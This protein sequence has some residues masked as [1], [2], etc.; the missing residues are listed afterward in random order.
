[1]SIV[2]GACGHDCP[3]TCSWVVE[4]RDG[5]AERLSGDPAHP[6][7]RGTLCAKVNHYLERVYHPDRVLYP[8][9]R[10][11]RKGEGRFV[12]V[13]WDEALRDIASRW[14]AIVDEAGA[15]AIL[16][17]SSA[18]T[19]GLIQ[20]ASLDRRL[21]G[22][23]GCSGL[24]RKICGGVAA[25]GLT[26]TIGCGT[27]ID[28]EQIVHSRF[29]V[30]WGTNTIVTN[31]HYWPLVREA[32]RRGA[33]V[34]AVDP[35]RTRTAEAVD[36]HLQIRPASD[37]ALAL[38][39]MHVMIRD[40]LVDHE[41]VSQHAIGYEA[42]ADRVRQYSPEAVSPTVG[43]PVHDIE[44][45]AR[46]YAT[47]QP[48]LLRPLIGIEHHRNGAMQFRTLACLAV[49][50]GAWKH[51][52]GGLARSTHA[53]QFGVLDM[54]SV[55][56]PEVHK[57]GVR[58]L[59]MR[60]LGA[61]LCSRDLRPPVR[62]LIVYGSNP[63]VSMP[64]EGRTREGLMRDDLFTVV[65]EL[66]VTETAR[67][68][69]Y[70][71]PATS[72]IEH[73]DL[74]PAWGHLYLALNRPA[75]APRGESVSN[76]EL[77][78]RLAS[79]LGRTEP[80]LVQSDES[81]L[82]AALASGH[83]WLEGITYER[84]WDEGYVRLNCPEDWRP[85]ANGGFATPSGKA[86]LYSAS[87]QELGHDP[88]P[89]AGEIRADES[90]QLITGKSL[91]FLNSGYSNMERHSRRAGALFVEIHPDDARTRGVA[92]GDAVRV[93][94]GRGEVRAVCSVSDRVRPGVVWMPFGGFID[95]GGE[96]RSV[97]VLT[98]VEPTDWGGGSGFYD[99]FVEVSKSLIPSP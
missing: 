22:S 63:V 45:F 75:I 87:L 40:G 98:P 17:Y 91:H 94:N 51:R 33:K 72:Q 79:A 11:G 16:P 20:T 53:I 41:Y 32:Q 95:A 70:V 74:S 30:L 65:H 69:D 68:A 49:L 93:W 14:R 90:L 99:A 39:M 38:A 46:E 23:M 96:R 27:G 56:M 82:R 52:G 5:V 55:T 44:R 19:Q 6:F 35:I 67:Y 28:P 43:L 83:P 81:M 21:F 9:K 36:W 66:F 48:S 31:L 25:A 3:D 8:L 76:T 59:N 34:V 61:D 60:D 58:T 18:G 2:R 77:F 54:D 47:T 12:R 42:L 92:S 13:S 15:E 84:L 37:A 1:M 71:L 73:L 97:N 29:I 7:T 85:F 88:L 10:E 62:S 26:A 78:R 89:W 64:D 50:S 4:V 80:W 86:E 24:E 57:P